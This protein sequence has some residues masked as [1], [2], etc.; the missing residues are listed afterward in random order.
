MPS[1]SN[2]TKVVHYRIRRNDC[3]W[4]TVDDEKFFENLGK[5][6]Q[7]CEFVSLSLQKVSL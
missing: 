6:V 2:G 5:L 4:V 1:Y 7:V 3:S